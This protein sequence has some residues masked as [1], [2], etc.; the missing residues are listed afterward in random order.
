MHANTSITNALRNISSHTPQI[1]ERIAQRLY[2]SIYNLIF[3]HLLSI[4]ISAAPTNTH[5]IKAIMSITLKAVN[6]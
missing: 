4:K 3:L 6:K 2:A 1:A 5:A